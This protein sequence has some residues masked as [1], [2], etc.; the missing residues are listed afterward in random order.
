MVTL[1]RGTRLASAGDLLFHTCLFGSELTSFA[2]EAPPEA[3]REDMNE[4]KKPP[5]SE[6]GFRQDVEMKLVNWVR[7]V[8][9]SNDELVHALNRLRV[10]YKVLLSGE[11]VTDAQ[12]ILKE[13]RRCPNRRRQSK[14]FVIAGRNARSKMDH[15]YLPGLCGN[16]FERLGGKIVGKPC[17]GKL[18]A[19][20]DVAGNGN[21]DMVEL[22]R[23]SQKETE[24]LLGSA[25]FSSAPFPD[26]TTHR[27]P[28]NPKTP[29]A[30]PAP[31]GRR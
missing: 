12:E 8:A 17:E 14:R 15:F 18:H 27:W 9:E 23:H 13:S 20:F 5:S 19:R 3:R 4:T 6:T 21:P 30:E 16:G 11:P 22:L 24:L 26:S 7:G 29:G 1:R 25:Y 2:N 31:E 10:S 28:R